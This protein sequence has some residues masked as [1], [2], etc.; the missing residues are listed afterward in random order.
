[1][2][3]NSKSSETSYLRDLLV[4]VAVSVVDPWELRAFMVP[5]NR[6]FGKYKMSYYFTFKILVNLYMLIYRNPSLHEYMY[7]L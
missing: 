2:L 7:A 5:I 4:A 1:M 3:I 6:P